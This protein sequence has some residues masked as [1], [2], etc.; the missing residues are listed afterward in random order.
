MIFKFWIKL[1][2]FTFLYIGM[3]HYAF[4]EPRSI[5]FDLQDVPLIDFSQAA[6]K[7]LMSSDYIITPE[8]S[9]E[10]RTVTLQ[11]Q[12]KTP[13]QALSIVLDTLK[14]Y[15]IELE[16]KDGVNYLKK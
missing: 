9:A 1:N 15:G 12:N 16:N 14:S 7:G 4:S 6:I 11:I 10:N 8:L 5:S 2:L 13:E 3:I